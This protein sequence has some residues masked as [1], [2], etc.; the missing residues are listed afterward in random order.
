MVVFVLC[1]IYEFCFNVRISYFSLSF[2]NKKILFYSV[3]FYFSQNVNTD[4]PVSRGHLG[5]MTKWPYK[6]CDLLKEVNSYAIFL[7]GQEKGD[8]SMQVTA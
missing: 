8:L 7:T 3:D 1:K 6:T 2:L 4:K 5:T